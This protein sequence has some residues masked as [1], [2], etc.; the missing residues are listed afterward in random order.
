[1]NLMKTAMRNQKSF[2]CN[3]FVVLIVISFIN[4][5]CSQKY[6][7]HFWSWPYTSKEALDI[8]IEDMK[9]LKSQGWYGVG[10]SGATNEPGGKYYFT[11]PT[12][13]SQS[14]AIFMGDRITPLISVAHA[15]G[16]KFMINM[17]WINPNF[18]PD[19][20]K[21]WTPDLLKG[22]VRD[23]KNCGI[24]RWFDECFNLWSELGTA[25]AE[26]CKD[27]D[28]EYEEGSDGMHIFGTSAWQRGKLKEGNLQPTFPGYYIHT[29]PISL[30]H[31]GYYRDTPGGGVIA[32]QGTIAY[33]FAKHWKKKTA[34]VYTMGNWGTPSEYWP[35]VL[36]ATCLIRSLQFRIDD[37][38]IIKADSVKGIQLNIPALK[39]WINGYIKNQDAL[40]KRPV[41]NIVTH[42]TAE[43][44]GCWL[45]GLYTYSGDAI[46]SGA[47]HAG[48]NVI[49]SEEPI[50]D[51]DAYY[52]YTS[53]TY[54]GTDNLTPELTN[55]FDI[56]KTVFLQCG[57]TIPTAAA[58]TN[59][60]KTVLS[61]CGV[62][63]SK[64]F[65]S[66]DTMPSNGI[67]KGDTLNFTGMSS[68]KGSP[69][70]NKTKSGTIIPLDAVT[71]KIYSQSGT[72]PLVVGQN[73]KYLITGSCLSWQ[74][75]YLIADLLNGCGTSPDSNVWGISGNGASAFLAISNTTLELRIPNLPDS[76]KIHVVQF[77]K[78]HNK[79]YEATVIYTAPFTRS[80]SQFDLI[81]IESDFNINKQAGSKNK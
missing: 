47:F 1:M 53:G 48:Y 12:L 6:D 63:W 35:G 20:L 50:P 11:S 24:D 7:P 64:S 38:M 74:M 71:G 80:M 16:L 23:L 45:W 25:I 54:G 44:S 27:L 81:T 31:Y 58:L 36:R 22:V 3:I 59:N 76:Q 61:K 42:L 37:Y 60:W 17:E 69:G 40:E 34:L 43:K 39:T 66:S 33:G 2:L 75:N 15:N 73:S 29:D 19:G 8:K 57:G 52:I 67:Y 79:I 18:W 78:Y 72:I 28:L 9:W 46:T 13:A 41:L 30:Y 4:F 70:I 55:L 65:S 32:Q 21:Y 62:E 5:S 14:W 68:M 56:K 51:A 49:C 26:Q 77:D 10:V